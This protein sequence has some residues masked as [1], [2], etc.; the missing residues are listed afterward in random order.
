MSGKIALWHRPTVIG[1]QA[2]EDAIREAADMYADS[3]RRHYIRD[4]YN[5][6]GR[7]LRPSSMGKEPLSLFAR[8]FFPDIFENPDYLPALDEDIDP[9]ADSS[10]RQQLFHEGDT[11]EADFAF[12]CRRTGIKIVQLHPKVNYKDVVKGTGDIVLEFDGVHYI[13]DLKSTSA[14]YFRQL[15]D[16]G[17]DDVRGYVTQL[18]I[19]SHGTG[20]PPILGV[21]CRDSC[22]FLTISIPQDTID[23]ALYNVDYF[24]HHW[25]NTVKCWEDV[26]EHFTP[27]PPRPEKVGRRLTG[28]YLIPIKFYSCPSRH[29]L[30]DIVVDYNDKGELRQYVVDYIYPAK[31]LDRKPEM[32]NR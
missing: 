26:F 6:D 22:N 11:W 9:L 30:Y 31:H 7:I 25:F 23:V 27:P 29:L 1:P 28:R 2:L 8:K 3:L 24:I 12:Q 20:L 17:L 5:E 15:V 18:A 32:P 21:Y 4:E 10:R 13:V 16:Y 19:Y 14:K